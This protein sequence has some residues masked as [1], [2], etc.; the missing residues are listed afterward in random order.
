MAEGSDHPFP[1]F[2]SPIPV[3]LV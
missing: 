1:G 2:P 3:H